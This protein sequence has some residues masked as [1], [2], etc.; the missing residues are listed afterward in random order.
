M[1]IG[2]YLELELM[3]KDN[4]LHSNL[5]KVNSGRNALELILKYK[6]C[7][8]IFIPYFTCD[9]ILEPILKLGIEYIFYDVNEKLEPVFDF[10]CLNIDDCFLYTNYFGIKDKFILDLAS[11][12]SSDQL[13]IDNA[14]SLFSKP[15][16]EVSSFY[17]PRKF[18]GVADGGY[19]SNLSEFMFLEQDYSHQ[20]MQHLLKRIELGANAGYDDFVQNDSNFKNNSIR[21]MSKLTNRILSSI[22][23]DFVKEKRL[24]N[25]NFLHSFL[26]NENLLNIDISEIEVPLVYPFRNIN[27][28]MIRKR[29]IENKVYCANYWPNVKKWCSKDFLSYGLSSEI[30]ALPIDQRY[31]EK[32][33][34]K[35][36]KVIKNG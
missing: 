12:L 24:N 10:D 22:D 27:G 13:V 17:S 5:I 34:L 3:V 29:L 32:E 16:E 25:F 18:V 31:S 23:Y 33:M 1:E 15:L 7:R 28:E 30:I 20:N 9:V 36:L 19:I 26:G 35:I 21:H 14:Q 6:K 2:G 4:Y 8:R 11:K